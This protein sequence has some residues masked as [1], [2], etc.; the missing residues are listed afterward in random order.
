M[1]TWSITAYEGDNVKFVFETDYQPSRD[2]HIAALR[3][4]KQRG[5]I[6]RFEVVEK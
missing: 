1:T 4:Q 3:K 6:T 5:D 2:A